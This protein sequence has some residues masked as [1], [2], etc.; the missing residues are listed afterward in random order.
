MR[1]IKKVIGLTAECIRHPRVI[2]NGARCLKNMGVK[3]FVHHAKVRSNQQIVRNGEAIGY[4]GKIKFSIVIPVYN[5]D[6]IW[7]EK[8]INSVKNQT[9]VNW[10]LCLVDDCST[11]PKVKEY[12]S[13][14][15]I[16]KIKVEFCEKN[17]GISVA[18][19]RG[20]ELATGD[21]ILL[22]D[23][24]DEIAPSALK[25]FYDE[26][27]KSNPDIL[28]SDQDIVDQYGNHRDP[29]CKPDWSP[30]LFLSQMYLGHLI[31]FKKS[32]FEEVGGF[33]TEFNGSQDYDLL[34][35]MIE[36]TTNIKHISKILYSWRDIPTSTAANPHSK[37]YAQ[38][39]GLHAI[40]E[41]LD[42]KYGVDKA[43]AVETKDLF[44]YDVRYSFDQGTKVSIIIPV[45][46]HVDLLKTLIDSIYTKSTYRNFE[47]IIL[48]NNSEKLESYRYFEQLVKEHE[49]IKVDNAFYE[50]N[51]SK[52]NNHGMELASGDVYVF[53][54]NDMEIITEDWIERLVEKA[55]RDDVG[56]VGPL[57]LFEDNTIQ[58]AG[59][60]A[61]MGG[62]AEHLFRGMSPQHYGSP[63][64]SPMV[65]RN[66]TACTGACMAIS[67]K[68]IEKIGGF[69]EDYLICGSD[70]ELCI[71][72]N[73]NG[74]VNVYD[75]HVQLYHYE[76]KSRTP[77]IPE[78]DFKHSYEL[79]APYRMDGDP[80]YNKQLDYYSYEPKM[81]V[82]AYQEGNPVVGEREEGIEEVSEPVT[83]EMTQQLQE[84]LQVNIPEITPYTFRVGHHE[85]KRLNLLV[86]SLN[87]EHVFGGI[88]TAL[89]F[90]N[91]AVEILGYD[92]RII[93]TDSAPTEETIKEY[94]SEYT[95]VSSEEE[96]DASKQ[97]VA[98]SDRY[99]KSIP[100]SANDYFMFTGWW[101]AYCTQDAYRVFK[102]EYQMEPNVFLNFIQ[103]YEPGFYPWSSRYLLADATYRSSFKQIA[104]F[105]TRLLQEFFNRNGYHF[106]KTF[107]FE[108]V[109]NAGLKKALDE[110]PE[111][112][113]KKKQIIVYGRPSVSRNAF[114]LVVEALRK[115]V[116]R[117]ENIEE[118]TI[119]SAGEL[120]NPVQLGKGKQLCSVGK[121]TIEEYAQALMDS[122]AAISLMAS[123]HPS[124]P[125]LEMSQFGIKVIT[126]TYANKDLGT[127]NQ[128]IISLED[129]SPAN[130]AENL[131]KVCNEFKSSYQVTMVNK[132]YCEN[133]NPFEF[134]RELPRVLEESDK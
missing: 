10:E 95:F 46:D 76:S 39:A 59:V 112:I 99:N 65:T 36:H 118:W 45:K 3:E 15:Q 56:V 115:W 54:N 113:E 51:W 116:E 104:V 98:Y 134:I 30:D 89:K 47:L 1:K 23:N 132:E 19:N 75:P 102:E 130:I 78:I 97:I 127:F 6:L 92:A 43:K 125:P 131:S 133:S 12:L 122:Y 117:Q 82:H 4:K 114:E 34:L 86:P 73:N 91:Q 5:V 128:N 29:L 53:M 20:V 18:S 123:P 66:I 55:L 7:L 14:I 57:L 90:Y 79:Y 32:L 109:L 8:A 42:R 44:V 108:P 35:R 60:V 106:Y 77:H 48:N 49:N 119:L 41:H 72:A 67:K 124:Y 26:I 85:R 33:R 24:D 107:V 52:L 111:E 103:D 64:I 37:P 93:L 83:A 61:G 80:Y 110:A 28:Y 81:R 17:G 68:T 22:M 27:I 13:T 87:K 101:T 40:Q 70:I 120:H 105:N 58:H 31:G 94:S 71:R 11:D 129:I 100:V 63:F 62:W 50:F 2:Y 121:L 96:S 69:N 88:S 9:Y 84:E 21:Y 25:E 126:N 74:L 38:T 16:S